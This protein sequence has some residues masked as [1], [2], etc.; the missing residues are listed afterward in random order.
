MR[1]GRLGRAARLGR[2]RARWPP[3]GQPERRTAVQ[4]RAARRLGARP[5]RRTGPSAPGRV[6]PP[7]GRRC[8]HR[9]VPHRRARGQRRRRDPHPLALAPA[10]IPDGRGI[11]VSHLPHGPSKAQRRSFVRSEAWSVEC[12][13]VNPVNVRRWVCLAR[14]LARRPSAK[15]VPGCSRTLPPHED[16]TV[17]AQRTSARPRKTDGHSVSGS[18]RQCSAS[19][20][21]GTDTHSAHRGRNLLLAGGC[22][23][24]L[25]LG[26][27]WHVWSNHPTSTS[28]CGCGDTS[29]FTWFLEWPAYALSHGLNPS[30]L[31]GRGL[32]ARSQSVGEHE[33]ARR[34]DLLG[35]DHLDLR[36][37]ATLNVALLLSPV[38]SGVAMFILLRRWVAWEPAAFVGGVAY[39]FSPIIVTSLDYSHL[40]ITMSPIPPLVVACLDEIVIR[41]RRRPVGTGVLLGLLLT[42]QFFLSTEL[43][44][45]I[46]LAGAFGLIL[47]TGYAAWR[48]PQALRRHARFAA[49]GLA[50]GA[51]VAV[52]LLA[53]PAWF[54]LAGPAHVSGSVWGD[55]GQYVSHLKSYVIPN[56]AILLGWQYGFDGSLISGHYLGLGLV[57]VLVG[58]LVAWRRD[59]R[60]R[61]F[62]ILGVASVALSLGAANPLLGSLPVFE[63]ILP[64]RFDQ[65]VYLSVAI[66]L[67]IVV[68]H[69][70]ASVTR[71]YTSRASGVAH[72]ERDPERLGGRTRCRSV[73][74]AARRTDGRGDRARSHRPLPLPE[75]PHSRSVVVPS[76]FVVPNCRS[77]PGAEAGAPRFA[78]RHQRGEPHDLAGC[79]WHSLCRRRRNGGGRHD[80]NK[81]G[82]TRGTGHHVGTGLCHRFLFK[83]G[84]RHHTEQDCCCPKCAPRSGGSLW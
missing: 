54:S 31:G 6:R 71:W 48:A 61:F 60:L 23:L 1:A 52:V 41:Q 73:G 25:S 70:Y 22:Y 66:M 55:L 3:P 27:W 28:I 17:L 33:R 76:P 32:P 21:A 78:G 37:I 13:F 49:A 42:L 38:L 15:G 4:G 79:R 84:S 36:P 68:D 5:G 35:T 24:L 12:F 65:V 51:I 18:R 50:A 40:M 45:I 77:A 43:L 34:R 30:L 67:G 7:P 69:S 75:S 29:V 64:N 2:H 9:A 74:L 47:V 16:I 62:G 11:R 63:N 14:V 46:A 56:P 26:M 39:G 8:T 10:S 19:Q 83:G 81:A 82:G 59:L 57:V 72:P 80:G 44:V 58:G 20:P 53:Y